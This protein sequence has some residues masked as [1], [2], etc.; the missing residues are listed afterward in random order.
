MKKQHIIIGLFIVGSLALG[1]CAR[2]IT[3]VA[4]DTQIDISGR[5]NDTDSRLSAEELTDEIL[6]GNWITDFMQA[7]GGKKPVLIVGLVRNKSH[8]HIE[9]ETFTKDIEKALIKREVARVVSGGEMREELRAERADQQTNASM[10][11]I[12]KF[13][14]E[15]GADFMLQG[16][17]NSIV[18]AHKREKVTY[19]QIDLELTN[20]QTN[21]KVWIGDKKI[22]KLIKN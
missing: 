13:G 17:I 18:D 3:R 9:A 16:N 10:S 7:N 20:I 2:K 6:T 19:Y 5:W 1:S 22:K 21:E 12:K 4:P 11:T 8:E 14:L 15:T